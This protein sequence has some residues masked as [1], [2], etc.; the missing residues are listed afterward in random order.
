MSEAALGHS[1]IPR[2]RHDILFEVE[3]L[4]G[5]RNRLTVAFRIILAIPHL[6]LVGGPGFGSSDR[7]NVLGMVAFIAAVINWFAILFT[8]KPIEGLMN[9]QV[10]YLRWRANVL[11]YAGLLRDEYPPFGEGTY[12]VRT[13]FPRLM[14]NR[15]R[16]SVFLRPFLLIPHVIVLFVMYFAWFVTA[17]IGWFAVLFA[18]SYPASFWKFGEGVFRWSLRVEAYAALLHD[19]FPPFSLD[20][21]A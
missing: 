1:D 3:P 6:L 18:G 11:A 7:S 2:E 21:D 10:Y 5:P 13:E 19:S 8:K 4:D 17:V 9:L 20:A 15:D 12:P 14:E 16:W